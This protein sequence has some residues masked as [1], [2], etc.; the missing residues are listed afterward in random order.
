[1]QVCKPGSVSRQGRGLI[2]YL[3]LT[4]LPGSIDLPILTH[5]VRASNS[6]LIN[7]SGQ[8]LFGLSTRKVYRAPNVTIGA[9][10]SYPTFSPLLRYTEAVCFLWHFLFTLLT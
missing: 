4:S 6:M 2:I 10:G 7:I 8:N 3:A 9:V 5:N 1:M